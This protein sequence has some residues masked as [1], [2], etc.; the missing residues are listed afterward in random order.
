MLLDQEHP[1]TC[2]LSLHKFGSSEAFLSLSGRVQY[3]ISL[4]LTV[5]FLTS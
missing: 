3:V 1:H 5:D 4:F 2:Y